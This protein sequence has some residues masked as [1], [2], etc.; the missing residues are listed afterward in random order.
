MSLATA[1][2]IVI[3][4]PVHAGKP[5]AAPP[6][7]ARLKARSFPARHGASPEVRPETL[8][9]SWHPRGVMPSIVPLLPSLS[10]SALVASRATTPLTRVSL[11]PENARARAV[12]PAR[13]RSR[14]VDNAANN[15]TTSSLPAGGRAQ[16]AH[17]RLAQGARQRQR[18]RAQRATSGRL[19]AHTC[20]ANGPP[21][22]LQ[23]HPTPPRTQTSPR[24]TELH[25]L[26]PRLLAKP[27][28]EAD[29]AGRSPCCKRQEIRTGAMAP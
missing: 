5:R 1:P 19:D 25:E 15:D 28:R 27:Q 23:L 18:R 9:E 12:A 26:N 14:F 24:R 20:D 8:T 21:P 4:V 16:G 29:D 7:A 6:V 13:P 3:K 22:A 10:T 17:R 11:P 2:S